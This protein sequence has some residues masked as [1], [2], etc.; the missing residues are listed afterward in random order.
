MHARGAAWST[1]TLRVEQLQS[2]LELAVSWHRTH[3]LTE[4]LNNMAKAAARILQADRASIFLWDRAAKELVGHPALGVE[5]SPLRI[6]DD[7]GIAG[8]V[9]KNGTPQRW[10][11]SDDPRLSTKRVGN[12]S[13]MPRVHFWLYNWSTTAVEPWASSK[14]S[15]IA[16]AVS[17]PKMK[18][19]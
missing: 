9:L 7:Q 12:N 1:A 8:Q 19:F 11:V 6:P 17:Q 5:G 14:C 2:L 18:P 16:R 15:I 3:D 4:L 10:D 13:A